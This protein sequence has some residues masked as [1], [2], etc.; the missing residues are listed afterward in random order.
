MI[1]LLKT[2]LLYQIPKGTLVCYREKDLVKR[3]PALSPINPCYTYACPFFLLIMFCWHLIDCPSCDFKVE[4]SVALANHMHTYHREHPAFSCSQ[5]IKK[6][7]AVILLSSFQAN[8]TKYS[9]Y[10][11]AKSI[12]Q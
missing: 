11:S 7:I 3:E 1:S 12:P 5:K 4:L 2:P 9:F 6:S 8:K 10:L